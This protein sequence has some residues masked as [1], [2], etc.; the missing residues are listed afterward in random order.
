MSLPGARTCREWAN[1][2]QAEHW[3]NDGKYILKRPSR[4]SYENE[5]NSNNRWPQCLSDL[6]QLRIH[7]PVDTL[8]DTS[9]KIMWQTYILQ[10][11]AIRPPNWIRVPTPSRTRICVQP[12]SLINSNL[13]YSGMLK[14]RRS[15]ISPENVLNKCSLIKGFDN[16][17]YSNNNI[18]GTIPLIPELV[19]FFHCTV[20][21]MF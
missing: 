14:H 11:L 10:S 2:A 5:T 19:Q 4:C 15:A 16:A 3:T 13:V 8:R 20:D 18:D 1:I 12:I 17:K 7:T 9:I 6:E 21:I